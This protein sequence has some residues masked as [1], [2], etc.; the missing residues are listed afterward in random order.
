MNYLAHAV[1]AGE[2]HSVVAGSVAGDFVK[3]VVRDG[4]FPP[5]FTLGIRL[6]RRL[7]AFSNAE[8]HLR[9]SADRVPAAL[10]RIAP[11]CI[12]V[13][14][15]HLLARAIDSAPASYLPPALLAKSTGDDALVAYE[16]ML[17]KLLDAH[18]EFTS[19]DAQRF[20]HHAQASHLFSEYRTFERTSRG[21]GY[22]CERL[23]RPAD[24]PAMI[25]AL[26]SNMHA[27]EQDFA[28][29]WPALR[30]EAER[31]LV[32]SDGIISTQH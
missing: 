31:F 13:L 19:P 2:N 3:G 30:Q 17:H 32:A 5:L 7:D 11:P 14:A 1:L 20:F 26:A 29:Y 27:L 28:D 6:H 16:A 15:D 24:A 4:D 8:P 12:D 9:A 25:N 22:V 23:R 10:R 18:T 21:I